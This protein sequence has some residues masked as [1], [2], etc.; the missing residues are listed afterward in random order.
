[1]P[2]R[3]RREKNCWE[4]EEVEEEGEELV[5]DEIKKHLLSFSEYKIHSYDEIETISLENGLK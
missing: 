2:G 5:G 3:R 1:M 4:K